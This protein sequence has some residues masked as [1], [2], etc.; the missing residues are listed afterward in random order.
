MLRALCGTDPDYAAWD[1]LE[2]LARDEQG[3]HAEAYLVAELN[4]NLE[5]LSK[6]GRAAVLPALAR[7]IAESES[8]AQFGKLLAATSGRREL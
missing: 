8:G 5:A 3:A 7:I 1:T 2:T 4:R 6:E